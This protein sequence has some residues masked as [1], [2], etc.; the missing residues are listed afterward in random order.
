MSQHPPASN[1]GTGGEGVGQPPSLRLAL[2]L[3]FPSS[4]P[5]LLAPRSIAWTL[6]P[7]APLRP[8]RQRGERG[9][10]GLCLPSPLVLTLFG[11]GGEG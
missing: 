9:R 4:N 6:S 1:A 7:G 3:C 5:Y 10:R 11:L 8:S 2:T